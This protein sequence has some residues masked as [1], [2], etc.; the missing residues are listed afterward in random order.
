[1]ILRDE[2]RQFADELRDERGLDFGVR[3]GINSG[4]VVVGKIGDDLRMD[5]TAQGQTVGIAQRIESLAETGRVY[6]SEATAHLVSE[7]F[8]LRSVGHPNIKGVD[9]SVEVFELEGASAAVSRIEAAETRGLTQFVGRDQ[10]MQMLEMVLA[11][12]EDG[13]GQVV[14][15]VGDPGLGKSRLCLEFVKR[16]R[17]HGLV[18]HEAHCPAHG[19]NVPFL[20][21]LELFRSYFGVTQQD[22]EAVAREKITNLMQRLDLEL[23]DALPVFFEFMG[24]GDPDTPPSTMDANV[25]QRVLFDL[26][27]RITRPLADSGETVVVMIDDL[28]WIDP[29]SDLFVAQIVEAVESGRVLLLL[30]FRPEYT[31]AWTQKSHYQQLPLVPLNATAVADLVRHLLGDDKTLR[32]MTERLLTWTEGNP[33]FAEEV[34]QMLIETGAVERQAGHY[35]LVGD[36]KHLEVP[37]NVRALLAARID[38]LDERSKRVLQRASVIGKGFEAPLLEDIAGVDA[39]DLDAALD[40]L[41][42]NEFIHDTALYPTRKYAFKHPLS[43]EVA[44]ASQLNESRRET[45]AAVA[46]ALEKHSQDRLDEMAAL[47]AHHWEEAGEAL[48]AAN[49]HRRSA[50]WVGRTDFV[51]AARHWNKVRLLVRELPDDA[52][53]A[54]LGIAACLQLLS[55]ALRIGMDA[56]EAR[57]VLQEGQAFA[58]ATDNRLAHIYLSGAHGLA[59]CT[60]GDVGAYLEI[61]LDNRRRLVATDDIR[62]QANV[63]TYHLHALWLAA[64]FSEA[65]ELSEKGLAVVSRDGRQNWLG[66][67]TLRGAFSLARAICLNWTGRLRDGI[68]ELGCCQRF[69]E[70]DKS[71]EIV[72]YARFWLTE[73]CYLAYDEAR[74]LASAHQADEM[75]RELGDPPNMIVFKQIAYGYAHLAAG[76]AADAADQMREASREK[77][78]AQEYAGQVTQLLAEALLRVGDLSAAVDAAEDAIALC[79]RSLR[80]NYE[81]IA[82]GVLARALLRRDGVAARAEVEAALDNAAELIDSTGA[83]TLAPYLLEW[84][85][86]LAAALGDEVTCEQLLRQAGQG[87][88]AIGAPRHAQRL[89]VE[90]KARSA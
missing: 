16:C 65:L 69:G 66:G 55:L 84:R 10:E 76:R 53:A 63:W 50:K 25:R 89:I 29:G 61:A 46:T 70:E 82:H 6:V 30:N 87:Y 73:G 15:V 32:P 35:R 68:E 74:A 77:R 1:M 47:F 42:N 58:D 78:A 11:R 86:E 7:F 14:G 36:L 88:D 26:I 24:I 72:A 34:I 41:K 3:L 60:A 48:N 18:V 13:F 2:L 5:Y 38:R 33:F 54:K 67:I 23:G 4:N 20:P 43:H 52:E 8:E 28:H 51:A 62:V 39:A 44:Y 31:A 59:L 45:H 49:W 81:A 71:R 57:L 56:D 37:S 64:R 90:R 80:G 85:A 22:S 40:T 75:S 27:H 12:S 17:T 83:R 79:R 9:G 21:I 19:R